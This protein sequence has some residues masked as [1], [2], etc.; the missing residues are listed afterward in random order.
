MELLFWKWF[1]GGVTKIYWLLREIGN[2]SASRTAWTIRQEEE[3]WSRLRTALFNV[4]RSFE[5]DDKSNRRRLV[6]L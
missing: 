6:V 1:C 4:A 3:H 2:M 5:W